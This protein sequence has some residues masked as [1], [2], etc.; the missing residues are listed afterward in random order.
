MVDL[1]GC[2][3]LAGIDRLPVGACWRHAGRRLPRTRGDRPAQSSFTTW[4]SC[5]GG[6]P[7]LAG[8]DPAPNAIDGI[9]HCAGC[10]ALAGIDLSQLA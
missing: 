2:P 7:A 5:K 4:H 3:A 8:I 10:P 9:T 1:G 6:C